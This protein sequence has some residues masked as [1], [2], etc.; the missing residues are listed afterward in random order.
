MTY[1]YRVVSFIG[2]TKSRDSASAVSGQ[3]ETLINREAADG[4][5]FVTL[6]NVNIEVSPGCLAGLFGASTTY[7]RYDQVIFRRAR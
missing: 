4:W 2:S 6:G 5:E 3:L 1:E 7:V